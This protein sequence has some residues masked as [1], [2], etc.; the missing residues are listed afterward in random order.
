MGYFMIA[1][2]KRTGHCFIATLLH[3]AVGNKSMCYQHKI[4]T[5]HIAIH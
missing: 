5:F 1:K 3:A 2:H 4:D